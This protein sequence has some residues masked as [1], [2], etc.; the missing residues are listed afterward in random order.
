MHT[1]KHRMGLAWG[2][3]HFK[4]KLLKH[5]YVHKGQDCSSFA[6]GNGFDWLSNECFS[7]DSNPTASFNEVMNLPEMRHYS[8]T[9]SWTVIW[10]ENNNQT[11]GLLNFCVHIYKQIKKMSKGKVCFTLD[12]EHHSLAFILWL[13]SVQDFRKDPCCDAELTYL[14]TIIHSLCHYKLKFIGV[15]HEQWSIT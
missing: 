6:C 13:V 11:N 10:K 9:T 8:N 5:L 14:L 3:S 7:T 1:G 2:Q 12:N 4:W 15:W